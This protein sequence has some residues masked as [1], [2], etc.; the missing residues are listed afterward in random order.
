MVRI[1]AALSALVLLC[2]AWST[3]ANFN[4]FHEGCQ[5]RRIS[6]Q[7]QSRML[8]RFERL[9]AVA[10]QHSSAKAIRDW[11][12]AEQPAMD[13]DAQLARQNRPTC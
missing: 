6:L 3:Y 8:D 4:K 10:G 7:L 2:F 9:G 5:Q 1:S 12:H 11:F 13:R